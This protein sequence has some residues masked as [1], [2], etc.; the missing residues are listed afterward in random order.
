MFSNQG[1]ILVRNKPVDPTYE[2]QAAL[3]P[4]SA[5][6]FRK[7]NLFCCRLWIIQF[8]VV[9]N[10]RITCESVF[11]YFSRARSKG[12]ATLRK[13][14]KLL[15]W[16]KIGYAKS[17]GFR[18]YSAIYRSESRICSRYL[19]ISLISLICSFTYSRKKELLVGH[20]PNRVIEMACFDACERLVQ[21]KR[22]VGK[23]ALL[24]R[25]FI[26]RTWSESSVSLPLRN[27]EV[28]S[29]GMRSIKNIWNI[30]VGFGENKTFERFCSEMS[31]A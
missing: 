20:G 7:V 9:G 5:F 4:L 6:L 12:F 26:Y 24:A 31:R 30:N 1:P 14:P 21:G 3:K 8:S 17:V 11:S 25:Y 19:E 13:V 22:D 27:L 10:R 15:F 28:W 16:E 23:K 2:L 29:A 18:F